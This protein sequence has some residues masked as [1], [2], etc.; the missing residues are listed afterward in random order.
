VE[1]RTLV[2]LLQEPRAQSIGHFKNSSEHPLGQGIEVSVFIGVYQRPIIIK[3]RS[4]PS[5]SQLLLAA[6]ERR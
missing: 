4:R 5:L 3:R 2:D 1:R 6:D